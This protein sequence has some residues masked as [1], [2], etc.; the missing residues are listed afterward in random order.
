[1]MLHSK[2]LTPSEVERIWDFYRSK[3]KNENLLE[4]PSNLVW[5]IDSVIEFE[6]DVTFCLEETP[7]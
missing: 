7:V 4:A 5:E 6:F 3:D 1:M 2:K